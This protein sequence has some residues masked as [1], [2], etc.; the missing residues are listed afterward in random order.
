MNTKELAAGIAA[1]IR[2][3]GKVRPKGALPD[4]DVY[5]KGMWSEMRPQGRCCAVVNPTMHSLNYDKDNKTFLCNILA[6]QVGLEVGVNRSG[7]WALVDWSD[8]HTTEEV[9]EALDRV[10]A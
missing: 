5:N 2:R 1:D 8:A 6:R 9:L 3:N 10:A 4:S 7:Y